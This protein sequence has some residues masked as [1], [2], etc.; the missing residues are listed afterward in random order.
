V[1]NRAFVLGASLFTLTIAID[2]MIIAQGLEVLGVLS[3]I[4]SILVF[5]S[6]IVWL[7]YQ[8]DGAL[9]IRKV[10][11]AVPL[12]VFGVAVAKMFDSSG[13]GM[14]R[15]NENIQEVGNL[16]MSRYQLGLWSV[17]TTL[18]ISFVIAASLMVRRRV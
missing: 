8:D 7:I 1:R 9:H 14:F 13:I 4:G 6:A 12:A 10:W 15:G 16:L 17:S 3:L 11:V 2:A 18:L 5:A